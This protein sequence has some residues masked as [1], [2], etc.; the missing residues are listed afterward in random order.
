MES[1][2]IWNFYV[3]DRFPFN[4]SKRKYC[5]VHFYYI[6]EPYHKPEICDV[7]SI[8]L[9]RSLIKFSFFG[10]PLNYLHVFLT[11]LIL[12]SCSKN[13]LSQ[14]S[15]RKHNTE[16]NNV[17]DLGRFVSFL[18][19]LYIKL[20]GWK[21]ILFPMASICS[22][23]NGNT[24]S[25]Y[26]MVLLNILYSHEWNTYSPYVSEVLPWSSKIVRYVFVIELATSKCWICLL[27]CPWGFIIIEIFTFPSIQY[28]WGRGGGGPKKV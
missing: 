8:L 6:C 23:A 26:V 5:T 10:R 17:T 7:Y 3:C 24:L 28:V 11:G 19:Y 20:H 21:G 4:P 27:T 14:K 22:W 18:F 16:Q 15:C 2:G 1:Q 25:C 13:V 9:P 12:S